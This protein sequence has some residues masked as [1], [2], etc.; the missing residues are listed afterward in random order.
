M[1]RGVRGWSVRGGVGFVG[2]LVLSALA[3]AQQASKTT[4]QGVFT[5]AQATRGQKA[6]MDAC[7][8]CHAEDLLGASGPALVGDFFANRFVG[9]NVQEM[10]KTIR[11]SM[12]Q[13]A[14]DSLGTPMYV[15]IVSFILKSNFSPSGSAELPT[16]AEALQQ[17]EVAKP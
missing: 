9:S 3:N 12:P 15:D 10:V 7:A 14:P 4:A 1:N 5:E 8:R 6:Y 13:E 2:V 17:I 11:R 16:D